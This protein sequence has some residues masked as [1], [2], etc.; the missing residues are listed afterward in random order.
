MNC[1]GH[2]IEILG[3]K[4]QKRG[5]KSL[6]CVYLSRLV[7]VILMFLKKILTIGFVAAVLF[8]CGD[9]GSSATD[10]DEDSS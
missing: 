10:S 8:A 1:G 4:W 2:N 6:I 9:N 3:S 5:P 7:G